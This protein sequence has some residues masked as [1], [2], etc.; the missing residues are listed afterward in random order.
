MGISIGEQGLRQTTSAAE[1]VCAMWASARPA[2]A[3]MQVKYSYPVLSQDQEREE[4]TSGSMK[5]ATL[6]LLSMLQN[7]HGIQRL[8]SYA[9]VGTRSCNFAGYSALEFQTA[10]HS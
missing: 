10:G 1:R 4:V 3:A 8:E 6:N 7:S 2:T 9:P 5:Y